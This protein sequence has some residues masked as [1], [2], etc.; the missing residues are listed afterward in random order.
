M[1]LVFTENIDTIQNYM[2]PNS[3]STPTDISFDLSTVVTLIIGVPKIEIGILFVIHI[4]IYS[5]DSPI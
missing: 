2:I 1:F 4:K 5:Y 3:K